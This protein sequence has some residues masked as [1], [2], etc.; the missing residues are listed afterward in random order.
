MK[1]FKVRTNDGEEFTLDVEDL[2][3]QSNFIKSLLDGNFN[4][5]EEEY[6]LLSEVNGNS[7]RRIIQWSDYYKN[8]NVKDN[9]NINA[10]SDSLSVWDCEFFKMD[11]AALFQLI[12]SANYMDIPKL[13]D[14]SCTFVANMIKNRTPDEIRKTFNIKNDLTEAEQEQSY[15]WQ[16]KDVK[17][18]GTDDMVMLSSRSK[19]SIVD[20]LKKRYMNDQIYTYIGPVLVSVNPFKNLPIYGTNELEIYRDTTLYENPPHIF[21]IGDVMYSNMRSE[22]TNQCG[23]VISQNVGERNFHIFY[24]ILQIKDQNLYNDCG[25]TTPNSFLYLSQS[26]CYTVDGIND[27]KD[28]EDTLN[29]LKLLNM[30]EYEV[31]HVVQILMGILYIGN[32]QYDENDSSAAFI[33]DTKV[34]EMV[35]YLLELDMTLLNEKLTSRE[36]DSKWGG[37]SEAIRVVYNY[38]QAHHAKD[39]LSKTI[40]FRLFEY[41][42]SV[43]VKCHL[44]YY[45]SSLRFNDS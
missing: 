16:S 40:Y 17:K 38:T 6:V 33:Y 8:D 37:Q 43:N 22:Q 31:N 44:V 23:R 13:L 29:A 21:A 20:N 35:A 30:D 39:A 5:E 18:T 4:D 24:Q 25:M 14:A 41:L 34:S 27:S 19:S 32:L 12:M 2:S 3:A 15:H 42:V 9:E 45:K 7:L 28:V 1:N 10:K 26:E 36:M 11:Q